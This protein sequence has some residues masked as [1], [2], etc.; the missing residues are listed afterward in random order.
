LKKT[1]YLNLAILLTAAFAITGFNFEDPSFQE[2]T[3]EYVLFILVIILG[4]IYF[5]NRFSKK[6][7]NIFCDTNFIKKIK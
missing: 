7:P 4:A 3:K 6:I 1:T 5:I 2:N